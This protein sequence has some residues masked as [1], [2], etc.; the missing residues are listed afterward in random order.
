MAKNNRPCTKWNARIQRE[1]RIHH[2]NI[3]F[4]KFND[5]ADVAPTPPIDNVVG[6]SVVGEF[7]NPEACIDLCMQ[8]SW[9]DHTMV[10]SA[11]PSVHFHQN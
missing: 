10:K 8:A 6:L 2:E 9:L 7:V 4:W 5:S 1:E 3:L 11:E